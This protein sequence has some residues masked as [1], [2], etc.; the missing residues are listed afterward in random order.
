[1]LNCVSLSFNH[2]HSDYEGAL[3]TFF[4]ENINALPYEKLHKRKWNLDFCKYSVT[5]K[6]GRAEVS[7]TRF[8]LL[9]SVI[10]KKQTDFMVLSP[11]CRSQSRTNRAEDSW[12]T[13]RLLLPP[14]VATVTIYVLNDWLMLR[15]C[16]RLAVCP[17]ERGEREGRGDVMR[18]GYI[19]IQCNREEV[20]N[21]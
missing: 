15:P 9:S 19:Y 13:C 12:R 10:K 2:G 3:G 17:R 5:E 6:H 18:C 4:R 11:C 21:E 1:M 20:M 7:W 14:V 8:V 16:P